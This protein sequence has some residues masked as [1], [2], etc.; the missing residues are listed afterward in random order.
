MT[1]VEEL[2][3]QLIELGQHPKEKS[4]TVTILEKIG[5]VDQGVTISANSTLLISKLDIDDLQEDIN[6]ILEQDTSKKSKLE[7]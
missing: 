7:R 3:Q 1:N 4:D 6:K 2:L 5:A